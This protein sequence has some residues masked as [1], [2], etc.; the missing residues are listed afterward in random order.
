MFRRILKHTVDICSH[1]LVVD[2]QIVAVFCV[3]TT[4]H[5]AVALEFA[6]VIGFGEFG[7]CSCHW[8]W[9]IWNL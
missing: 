1:I 3:Y 5:C 9:R 6:P 8:L 7:I 2:V 4:V